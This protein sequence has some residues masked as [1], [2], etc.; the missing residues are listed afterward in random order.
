MKNKPSL[1]KT[2]KNEIYKNVKLWAK[3][4]KQS[5]EKKKKFPSNPI[6]TKPKKED[7]HSAITNKIENIEQELHELK[8]ILRLIQEE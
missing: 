3:Q 7:L 2:E 5:A 8:N 4:E 6:V 1:S